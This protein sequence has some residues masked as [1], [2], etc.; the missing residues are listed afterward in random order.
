[1][2][3]HVA[4]IAHKPD[5]GKYGD[6]F[7]TSIAAILDIETPELVPHFA[8]N[9][10]D[11]LEMIE[12]FRKWLAR[13]NY[14][15]IML[16]YDGSQSFDELMQGFDGITVPF[17]VWGQTADGPHCVICCNGALLHDVALVRTPMLRGAGAD[18]EWIVIFIGVNLDGSLR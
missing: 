13:L 11:G 4:T 14:A 17:L 8:D 15:P 1:M 7:R 12:R 3:P 16:C 9:G 18:G 5:V 2:I 6:C 10:V